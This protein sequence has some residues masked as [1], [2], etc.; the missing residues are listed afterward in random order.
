MT[1]PAILNARR[2]LYLPAPKPHQRPILDDPS[3]RKLWRAGRRTGKSRAALIATTSGHGPLLD[4]KRLLRGIVNGA[5]GVWIAPDFPQAR[6]IWREEIEPRFAGLDG[7]DVNQ[8]EH[9][10]S[11]RG[12]GRLELRSAENIDSVRGSGLDFAVLDEAAHFDLAYGLNDVIL[13]ALL[14]RQGWL[15]VISSPNAGQDGNADHALPSYFNRLVREILDDKRPEWRAWHNRTED[16]ATLSPEA[17][18]VLRAEYLP[19]SVTA[20]QELDAELVEGGVG[21]ALPWMSERDHVVPAF[22]V[23]AHWFRFGAIDW[24]YAHWT[25]VG[26]FAVDPYGTV[27]L[28]D[29][30][31]C[32]EATPEQIHATVRQQ[33]PLPLLSVIVGGWDLWHENRKAVGLRGPTLAEYFETQGWKLVKADVDRRLGLDNLRRYTITTAAD[34]QPQAPRFRLMDTLGNRQVFDQL[35]QMQL[36][37]LDPETPLKVDAVNGQGGD[38]AADCVRY[39]LMSRPLAGKQPPAVIARDR[40]PGYSYKE[41]REIPHEDPEQIVQ[42]WFRAAAPNPTINRAHVPSNRGRTRP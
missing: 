20:R 27:Y 34:G 15:F 37:P 23:P 24:G 25:V 29:T 35:V 11:I 33:V 9:R 36:D 18:A 42:S 21:F 16:N 17:I 31:W 39:G 5:T 26:S 13:P 3:A 19:G 32:R 30:V 12:A 1:A 40:T 38:D 4:G 10:V 2:T 28:V 22:P 8:A 6:A 41:R 14:D 7:V